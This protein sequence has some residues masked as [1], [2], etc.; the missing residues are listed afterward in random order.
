MSVAYENALPEE[1][2][3]SMEYFWKM[4]DD[5]EKEI[6]ASQELTLDAF[7]AFMSRPDEWTTETALAMNVIVNKCLNHKFV[8]RYDPLNIVIDEATRWQA[9]QLATMHAPSY[10]DD[11]YC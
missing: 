11:Y 1:D 8:D 5:E 2:D 3:E 4:V 7:I 6:R 9:Q 10:G